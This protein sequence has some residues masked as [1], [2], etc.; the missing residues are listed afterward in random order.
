MLVIAIYENSEK[1]EVTIKCGG[2][3]YLITQADFQ[4]LGISEG[5]FLDEDTLCSLEQAA[6]KL[7]C[8]KSAF[9]MLSYNDMSSGKLKRKLFQKYDK[10]IAE[11]VVEML[12]ERGYIND[13]VLACRYAESFYSSKKWGPARIKSELY[14]RGFSSLDIEEALAPIEQLDHSENIRELLESKYSKQQLSD[15]DT[16]RKA[17]AYL[18]RQGYESSDI[19]EII[20]L[21]YQE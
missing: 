2:E 4:S 11:T 13:T 19:Y 18:Y 17:A 15:R 14:S 10:D 7:S 20:N 6:I 9:S 5:D 3:S 12:S 8:I 1:H 21:I 16:A